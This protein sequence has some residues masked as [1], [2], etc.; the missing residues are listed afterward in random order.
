[1]D[2]DTTPFTQAREDVRELMTAPLR[3]WMQTPPAIRR[4]A[5]F[6]PLLAVPLDLGAASFQVTVTQSEKGW[7]IE[8]KRQLTTTSRLHVAGEARS[9]ISAL[10]QLAD[11]AEEAIDRL[12]RQARRHHEARQKHDATQNSEEAA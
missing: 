12:Q 5:M 10:Y 6:V 1:M 9:Y 7:R 2:F 11:S 3:R 8:A 4:D